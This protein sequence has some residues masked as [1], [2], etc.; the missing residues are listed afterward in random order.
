MSAQMSHS[1]LLQVSELVA[2][3]TGLRFPEGRWSD[4]ERGLA[5]AS[6]EFG[7]ETLDSF[8]QWLVLAS[9]EAPQIEKLASH[10]TVGETYFLRERRSFEALEAHALPELIR[11]RRNGEKRLRFWSAGCCTGEEPYSIAILL[12]R[13]LDLGSWKVSILGTDINPRSLQKAAEGVYGPWSFR[14]TPNWLREGYFRKSGTNRH[15]ILPWIRESVRFAL[16]NLVEDTYPS[17]ENGTNAMDVIFCRNVLMYFDPE[18]ARRAIQRLHRALVD[19]GWLVVSPV[20]AS[21]ELFEGFTA[22]HFPGAILYRK[23]QRKVEKV[24]FSAPVAASRPEVPSLPA[25]QPAPVPVGAEES[26]P[27]PPAAPELVPYEEALRLYDQGLYAEAE[28][29]LGDL[30]AAGNGGA[31]DQEGLALLVRICANQG[32]LDAG[33]TWCEKG[34]VGDRLNPVYLYLRAI[35]LQEQERLQEAG[36][37]LRKALYLDAG[38]TMV[39]FALGSLRLRQ[40]RFR[41]ARKSFE[42]ALELLSGSDPEE[43]VPHAEGLT[44]GRLGEM[45]TSTIRELAA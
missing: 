23:G 28:E 36:E 31:A 38:F 6:R 45:I 7:F 11:A 37:A 13:M 9:L 22:V 44:A 33:L 12:S 42:N 10:L 2:E 32:K 5:V 16:L 35:L 40:G 43:T 24:A 3:K 34:A 21:P 20:E 29:M 8:L 30:F 18:R 19:G 27:P 39:H 26:A 15:E 1:A 4:L 25:L 14:D 41:E 17:L